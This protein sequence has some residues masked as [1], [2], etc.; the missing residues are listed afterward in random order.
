VCLCLS[1]CERTRF[2]HTAVL[3]LAKTT[4]CRPVDRNRLIILLQLTHMLA[5]QSSLSEWRADKPNRKH[6]MASTRKNVFKMTVF[7]IFAFA[8]CWTPYFVISMVRIYSNYRLR[9]KW[10]LV[11]AE[12]LGLLHS[13]INPVVYVMY[14]A[15]AIRRH[16][17][18]GRSEV[19]DMELATFRMTSASNC[20]M[21]GSVVPRKSS[22][23]SCVGSILSTSTPQR[24]LPS[25]RASLV[26][27][28]D[29][30]CGHASPVR[31]LWQRRCATLGKRTSS[32][33]PVHK[34]TSGS[35]KV[36]QER[37][38]LLRQLNS[39][40]RHVVERVSTM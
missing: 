31:V 5:D 10:P 2:L 37:R 3:L 4:N 6:L 18:C 9:L 16:F 11:M 23:V 30:F 12:L 24:G 7:V 38:V 17:R 8:A 29:T 21:N 22:V 32:C 20:Q 35:V 1:N 39:R 40:T 36:C 27:S 26:P 19:V 14:S 25:E 15:S 13:A 34:R 33:I 28:C